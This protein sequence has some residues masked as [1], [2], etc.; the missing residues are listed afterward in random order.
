MAELEE[1]ELKFSRFIKQTFFIFIFI[2]GHIIVM[3]YMLPLVI[4][5]GSLFDFLFFFV[6]VLGLLTF[7]SVWM[8]FNY[9]KFSINKKI[10]ISKE[11]ITLVNKRSGKKNFIAKSRYRKIHYFSNNVSLSK[12]PWVFHEH[13]I[14][15][16]EGRDPVVITSYVA[17]ILSF[18]IDSINESRFMG[19]ES[20]STKSIFSPIRIKRL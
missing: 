3:F 6:F 12:L 11:G 19:L 15:E 14:I 18:Q 4:N 9:L 5:G 1:Y 17:D 7:P 20:T 16:V 10:I 2:S 13:V 8:L